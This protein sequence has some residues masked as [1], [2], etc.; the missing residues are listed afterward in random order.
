MPTEAEDNNHRSADENLT[1][2]NNNSH[3]L[4]GGNE[5]DV[6]EYHTSTDDC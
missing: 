1:D 5:G 3:S 6:G 2:D 4:I